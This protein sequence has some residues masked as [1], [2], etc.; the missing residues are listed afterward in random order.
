MGLPFQRPLLRT[1]HHYYIVHVAQPKARCDASM[2]AY[3]ST[4]LLPLHRQF[5]SACPGSSRGRFRNL[6]VGLS[7]NHPPTGILISSL[8]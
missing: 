6:S 1:P 4:W 3:R 7:R 8:D 2:E 5:G